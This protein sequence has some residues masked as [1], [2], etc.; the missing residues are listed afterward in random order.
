MSPTES[1]RA[2]DLARE[3]GG[4]LSAAGALFVALVALLQHAP[5]WLACLRGAATLL[6]LG[7][8]TRLGAAALA[9]AIESDRAQARSKQGTRP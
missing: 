7:F 8:G 9:H 3:L 1:A 2:R 4:R 6:L 5:L